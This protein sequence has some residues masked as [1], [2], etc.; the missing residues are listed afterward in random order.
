LDLA[1]NFWI[2]LK[3]GS[4][5][6]LQHC[7]FFRAVDEEALLAKEEAEHN[8]VKCL[9]LLYLIIMLRNVVPLRI[10]DGPAIMAVFPYHYLEFSTVVQI[11]PNRNPDF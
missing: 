9:L 8:Q 6:D 4:R 11:I 10:F 5:F 7:S 2:L 3:S 1:K